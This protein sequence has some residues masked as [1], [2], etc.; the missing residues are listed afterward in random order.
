M[1]SNLFVVQARLVCHLAGLE[2]IP[3]GQDHLVASSFQFSDNRNK[4]RNVRCV[5]QI[6]PDLRRLRFPSL[7]GWFRDRR[8]LFWGIE[9]VQDRATKVPF[10]ASRNLA[11][12]ITKLAFE[13][14]LIIYY[15]QGCADGQ[16]G[17]VIMLGPPLIVTEAQLAEIVGILAEAVQELLGA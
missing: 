17:D 11:W 1:L 10:P 16:N 6:D 7:S 8:G 5:L 2:C 14:G 4:E 12:N 9:L 3:G 13:K 15:S